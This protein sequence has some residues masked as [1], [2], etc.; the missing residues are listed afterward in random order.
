MK[1]VIGFIITQIIILLLLSSCNSQKK[2]QR[3]IEKNGIKESITFI[4]QKYP[5]YFKSKDTIIIDTIVIQD[6]IRIK[7]DTVNA[8]LS[9]SSNFLTLNNDSISLTIDKATNKIRIVYK[10]RLVPITKVIYRSVPCPTIVCPDCEDLK[11]YTKEGSSFK[12][13]MLIVGGVLLGG[14]YIWANRTK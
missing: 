11:D 3:R 12:W 14:F 5:E 8:F 7:A 2:L 4:T 6:T 13:W 9:D 1:F 10:E